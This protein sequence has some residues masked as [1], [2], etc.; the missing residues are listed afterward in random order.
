MTSR[1]VSPALDRRRSTLD[2]LP[3]P[4]SQPFSSVKLAHLADPHLGYPP[5]PPPDRRRHQPA[6]GRRRP[7]RSG[8]AIDGVIAAR[9][10]AVVVAGDLFH[11]GPAHQPGHRLRFPPV[12]AAPGG[13]AGGAGRARSPA[14]TIPRGRPRP[15]PSSG[16]STSSASRGGRARPAGWSFPTLDLCVLAVP[17]QA[18]IGAERPALRPEGAARYQV[19]VLHGEVEGVFPG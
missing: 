11:C 18:L 12:P 3:L 1:R 17:H 8:A 13:A 7:R 6:G 5:V 9:P 16:S 19:L 2:P 15:A 14:I 4:P 10:D